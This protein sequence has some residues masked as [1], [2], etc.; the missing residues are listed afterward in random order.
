M[1]DLSDFGVDAT[2]DAPHFQKKGRVHAGSK[3]TERGEVSRTVGWWGVC[4]ERNCRAYLTDRDPDE[5]K[6]RALGGD[7]GAW[8]ISDSALRKLDRLGVKRVFVRETTTGDV[9]EYR[10][11]A[12][13]RRVPEKMNPPEPQS[14]VPAGAYWEK[15]TGHGDDLLIPRDVDVNIEEGGGS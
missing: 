4:P 15:W 10:L 6:W 7:A 9:Y 11:A 12:F 1:T 8:A 5:H 3:Q 13:D 14:Y 2:P